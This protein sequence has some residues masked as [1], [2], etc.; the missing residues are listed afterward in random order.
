MLGGG[1]DK[2]SWVYVGSRG[3]LGKTSCSPILGGGYVTHHGCLVVLASKLLGRTK[4]QCS[5]IFY[6]SYISMLG[7]NTLMV[8]PSLYKNLRKKL[9]FV[10]IRKSVAECT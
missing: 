2:T 5:V 6:Q 4:A 3:Q 10:K 7:V 9:C 8:Q 1:L